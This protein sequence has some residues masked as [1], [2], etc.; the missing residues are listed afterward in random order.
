MDGSTNE[1]TGAKA[2]VHGD[3]AVASSYKDF[4]L[5]DPA[6]L[7]Q[8]VAQLMATRRRRLWQDVREAEGAFRER[9]YLD[10]AQ[11]WSR[12]FECEED[13]VVQMTK[14]YVDKDLTRQALEHLGTIEF[15]MREADRRR[16]TKAKPSA[17]K[18]PSTARSSAS[19]VFRASKLS[20]IG[21]ASSFRSRASRNG[22][23]DS[24][25]SDPDCPPPDGLKASLTPPRINIKSQ[26]STESTS[27]SPARSVGQPHGETGTFV[28][29]PMTPVL[30][31]ELSTAVSDGSFDTHSV[32]R[33]MSAHVRPGHHLSQTM[34]VTHSD[35]LRLG[36]LPV[37]HSHETGAARTSTHSSHDQRTLRTMSSGEQQAKMM[38]L[39]GQFSTMS[40]PDYPPTPNSIGGRRAVRIVV[41]A[42]PTMS[43]SRRT[44]NLRARTRGGA[45]ANSRSGS[46][47]VHVTSDSVPTRPRSGTVTPSTDSPVP[48]RQRSVVQS[49][50]FGGTDIDSSS[51]PASRGGTSHRA[52]GQEAKSA[53]PTTAVIAQSEF[54]NET[55][56]TS[57]S[58]S[59]TGYDTPGPSP[60]S[61]HV[62]MLP[63]SVEQRRP[64]Q[65]WAEPSAGQDTGSAIRSRRL[66]L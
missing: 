46:D 25:D 39:P 17:A 12:W 56:Y 62:N 34:P 29:P 20:G 61:V 14:D 60:L 23:S 38:A 30:E 36:R 55:P 47:A 2:K 64:V 27:R 44:L 31:T 9:V 45:S 19:E 8:C 43:V 16:Q 58:A 33:S 35:L 22:T 63:G 3:G 24:L 13:A 50:S 48:Q 40:T 54:Q 37:I 26:E 49:L 1:A 21:K 7:K 10:I 52:G 51:H 5:T 28:V 42:S 66:E 65:S 32:H 11:R 18:M 6:V 53:A 57:R 4:D 41:A 15:H 59:P